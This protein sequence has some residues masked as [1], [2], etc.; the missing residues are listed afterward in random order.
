MTELYDMGYPY[1]TIVTKFYL[2]AGPKE[3]FEYSVVINL[4]SAESEILRSSAIMRRE[5]FREFGTRNLI[6]TFSIG[7]F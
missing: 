7:I 6:I 4:K 1:A 2:V 3:G 5:F